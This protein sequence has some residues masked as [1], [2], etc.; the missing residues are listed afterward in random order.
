MH[1]LWFPMKGQGVFQKVPVMTHEDICLS[2]SIWEASEEKVRMKTVEL[3]GQIHADHKE[4]IQDLSVQAEGG[5]EGSG[6][7]W[8]LSVLECGNYSPCL[9]DEEA[10]GSLVSGHRAGLQLVGIQT[11]A[12]VSEAGSVHGGKGSQVLLAVSWDLGERER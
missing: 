4:W 2:W 3:P 9:A 11:W 10:K 8:V 7:L 6:S 12:I 5:V 1:T